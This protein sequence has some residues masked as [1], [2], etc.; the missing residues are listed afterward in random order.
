MWFSRF[1]IALYSGRRDAALTF[2]EDR[3]RRPSN[4][5]EEEIAAIMRVAQAS[6][7]PSPTLID[8]VMSEQLKSASTACGLA[9]NAAQ[10]AT[11]LGRNEAALDILRA[12]YFG[13]GFVVP[14]VRFTEAQ[15]TYT[16]RNDRNTL[17]LFSPSLAPLRRT[18]G[19]GALVER[20]GLEG[21]WREAGVGPDYRRG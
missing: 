7:T 8:A 9:E 20:L 1:F 13:E 2:A 17:F 5:A 21:Y 10:F 3:A 6:R 11:L 19:F 16:P 18:A 4:I 15:G 12:Y 14:E